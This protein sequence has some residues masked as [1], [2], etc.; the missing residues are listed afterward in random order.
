[1]IRKINIF[2]KN[3][4]VLLLILS[5][6]ISLYGKN[7]L[8]S[9]SDY[10]DHIIDNK[11]VYD[12]QK[13]QEINSLKKLL[14]TDSSLEYEFEINQKLAAEYKK[15]KLDS[16]IHYAEKGREIA[17]T[18]NQSKL[19][20]ISDINLA[21]LYSYAGR[22][23][24][25]EAILKSINN[26]QLPIELLPDYYDTYLR[27]FEHYRAVSNQSKYIKEMEMY[28]DSLLSV[29]DPSTFRYKINIIHRYL[30]EADVEKT[31]NLL[32]NLLESVDIDTPEYALVTHYLAAVNRRKGEP[33]LVKKYYMLSAIAD[34][35]NAIKENASAQN[36][37]LI[38][39]DSGDISKAFKYTQSAIEDAVFSGVQFRTAQMSKF[40]SIINA[41]YQAKEAKTNKK[42]KTYLTLI[43]ILSVFLILLAAYIY[44]QMKKVSAIK[45]EL[46]L[47]NDKLT[48]LNNELNQKN[49][50]LNDKNA[51]L[52]EA[53]LV[54]EQYIAQF[55]NLCSTYIDKMEDY[56]KA[57]YKVGINRHYEELMKK[58]KSTSVVDNEL[59][60]LYTHFDSIFLSLYPTFVSE[61][62]ALL[63]DDEKII[64]KSDNLL[65]KEL[66]IYAL[67]RLGITDNV[68]ISNFLRCSMSTIYN[69]RTKMRNKAAISREDFEDI[70]MKI[71]TANNKDQ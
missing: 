12:A 39:Y 4:I 40:Y 66:R 67:L 18:L 53:N 60:E 10:L 7:E 69:Y 46:S 35:K 57:L 2:H 42:L 64:L 23:R 43:S 29:S 56:R 38:Y 27:F 41:S 68:K 30:G 62:N 50:L 33:E 45:E 48:A 14:N 21:S 9:I 15:F 58:L 63:A 22:F 24:E 26:K 36:L 20:S 13:E 52:S 71:G 1:M 25:S 51:E 54:K 16:A 47:T 19:N 6:S 3:Y 44:K 8:K 59:D 37:A 31:E 17:Y 55:F 70:V 5:F 34:I 61:F 49:D 11:E 65:N 28:R 32:M